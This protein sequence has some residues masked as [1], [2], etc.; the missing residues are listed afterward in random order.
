MFDSKVSIAE[1]DTY[2]D[3]AKKTSKV[4]LMPNSSVTLKKIVPQYGTLAAEVATSK[5]ARIHQH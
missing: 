2:Q 1:M 4:S 3:M 5:F